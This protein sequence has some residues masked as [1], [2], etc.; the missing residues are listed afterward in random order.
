LIHVSVEIDTSFQN[1]I[2]EATAQKVVNHVCD[3][4]QIDPG[5][6]T[7]IFTSDETLRKMKNQYFSIDAYTDV[8]TFNLEDDGE[9]IDGEIYISP[10]RAAENTRIF[11]ESTES[12]LHRLIIHGT[13]HLLGYDD[14][15]PE[16][17][18][19]MKGLEDQYLAEV[20]QSDKSS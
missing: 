9:S 20:Y 2:N 8:I 18:K 13:L 16:D 12:E 10:E 1:L 6:V 7:I 3:R 11:G 4:E 19:T 17:Q 5:N 15:L 14:Q